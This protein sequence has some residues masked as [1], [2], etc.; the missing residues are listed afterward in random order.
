MRKARLRRQAVPARRRRAARRGDGRVL[1]GATGELV[2]RAERLRRLLA[3]RRGDRGGVLADG[4]LRTGDVAERDDEGF[5]RIRGRIK[6]MVISGGENVYPAE[7]ESVLHEHPTRSRTRPSSACRTSAGARSCIA[8]VV[9]REGAASAEE[10][11]EHCG[12]RLARFKVP[13]AFRLVDELPRSAMDKVRKDELPR[14]SPRLRDDR[15]RDERRRAAALEARRRDAAQLLEAAEEVFAELGYHEAS[16][17]KITE[18]AGRRRRA[19]ST[20]TSRARRRSS[21]RSSST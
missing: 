18:A 3:E 1:E 14:R 6:D 9:L 13:R 16:I 2:A 11:V 8:F 12:A 5:Y 7:V 10:L 19:R 17:V 15:G 20:S 4:W 21:R